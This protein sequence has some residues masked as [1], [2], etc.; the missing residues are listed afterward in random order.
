MLMHWI[1]QKFWLE[2]LCDQSNFDFD[3]QTALPK[4]HYNQSDCQCP[5]FPSSYSPY[6]S[7][8]YSS[9]NPVLPHYPSHSLLNTHENPLSQKVSPDPTLLD[10][11]TD[12]TT[13]PTPGP[14]PQPTDTRS[15]TTQTAITTVTTRWLLH[16]LP[17]SQTW[18]PS[19]LIFLQPIFC[20]FSRNLPNTSSSTDSN[21]F[22]SSPHSLSISI[23]IH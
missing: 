11:P 4:S 15:P 7:S 23:L 16:R 8:P 17:F 10:D 22:V 6:P 1:W 3:I 13:T 5:P 21:Y 18:S 2:D 20:L 14:V 19:S 9:F 12:T